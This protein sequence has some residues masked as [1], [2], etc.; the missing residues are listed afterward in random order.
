MT[1]RKNP[2]TSLAANKKADETGLK[3]HHQQKIINALQK[4]GSANY[5]QIASFTGMDRHAVGRRLS[6]LERAQIVYKPGLKSPTKSGRDAFVYCL[7][8]VSRSTNDMVNDM[9][10]NATPPDKKELQEFLDDMLDRK[11]D[12]PK[13]PISKQCTLF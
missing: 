9:I 10:Q 12:Q 8:G 13:Q 11:L 5:E 6:E 3:Q 4:I 2:S 7:V 1:T